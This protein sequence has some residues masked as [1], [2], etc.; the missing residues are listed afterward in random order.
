MD[1][2]HRDGKPDDLLVTLLDDSS[3]EVQW[4]E[5]VRIPGAPVHGTG[6]ALASAIAA[7]LALGAPLLDAVTRARRFVAAAIRRAEARGAGA[8]FL[9]FSGDDSGVEN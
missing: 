5:G 7:N 9:V 8:R 4:L 3:V 6:C 1:K 2:R